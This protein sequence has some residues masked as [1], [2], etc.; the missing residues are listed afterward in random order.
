MAKAAYLSV[1]N[2]EQYQHYKNR[3]PPWIKLYRSILHD[4][5]FRK[6]SEQDRYRYIGCLILACETDNKIPL[7]EVYLSSILGLTTTKVDLSPLIKGGLLLAHGAITSRGEKSREEERRVEEITPVGEPPKLVKVKKIKIS[8]PED[9]VLSAD[10]K[11]YAESKG[12]TDIDGEFEH[13]KAHHRKSDTKWV[14]WSAAWET[15]VLNGKKFSRKEMHGKV[16]LPYSGFAGK[17][18]RE[19]AF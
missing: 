11:R 4:F 15:W 3:N 2:F 19:G 12:M 1:K 16:E 7:N 14:D 13:F 8:L 10:M 9:F 17:N 6:L 18:Y 5:E